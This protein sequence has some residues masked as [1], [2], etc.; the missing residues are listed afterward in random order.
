MGQT[1]S[2]ILISVLQNF[3]NFDVGILK[4]IYE[5]RLPS[6]DRATLIFTDTA[7]VIA[8]GIPAALIIFSILTKRPVLRK[9]AAYVFISVALSAILANVLKYTTDL[10]RPYELY[11]FIEKLGS[12]GS[13]SFPSGHTADAFAFAMAI[14]LVWR[15]WQIVIPAFIWAALVGYTRIVLGVHFPSDVLAGAL[16]G[17]ICALASYGFW[18]RI[19]KRKK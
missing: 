1:L 19:K 4:L 13:P 5:N 17:I 9:E 15:K 7:A 14:S 18:S 11:P 2:M 6:L 10:P 8:F 3:R 12:G 16:I